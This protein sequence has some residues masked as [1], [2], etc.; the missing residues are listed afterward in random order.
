[1]IEAC[2]HTHSRSRARDWIVGTC[3]LENHGS[4]RDYSCNYRL[5]RFLVPIT[6]KVA[7]RFIFYAYQIIPPTGFTFV[8]AYTVLSLSHWSFLLLSFIFCVFALITLFNDSLPPSSNLEPTRSFTSSFNV[9]SP[10]PRSS[11]AISHRVSARIFECRSRKPK[12]IEIR[13][14]VSPGAGESSINNTR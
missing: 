9:A 7:R 2:V 1:M 8:R 6:L 5:L 4:L 13:I 11:H 12:R 3:D 14:A 10:L